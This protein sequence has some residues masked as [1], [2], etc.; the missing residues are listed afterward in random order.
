[1]YAKRQIERLAQFGVFRQKS[2][3]LILPSLAVSA[4]LGILAF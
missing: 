1:M 2:Q 4:Q 3:M